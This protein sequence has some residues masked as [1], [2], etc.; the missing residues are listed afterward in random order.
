MEKIDSTGM[1]E[2]AAEKCGS[3]PEKNVLES[4]VGR[5]G[6]N[7]KR[8]KCVARGMVEALKAVEARALFGSTSTAL[9]KEVT[10]SR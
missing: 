7:M 8:W 6:I 4:A 2:G 3:G 9:Y 10:L 1:V 5:R